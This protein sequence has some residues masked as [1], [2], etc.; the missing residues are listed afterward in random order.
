MQ[1][2]TMESF[3]ANICQMPDGTPGKCALG[4]RA[5]CPSALEAIL[6][7]PRVSR[8]SPS[9]EQIFTGTATFQPFS[10]LWICSSVSFQDMVGTLQQGYSPV[11]CGC[12]L[13]TAS[14]FLVFL[15]GCPS[16][17][18]PLPLRIWQKAGLVFSYE[19]PSVTLIS[20]SLGQ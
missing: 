15:P 7:Q 10:R 16:E 1:R 17:A 11:S 18:H 14:A 19:V 6:G 13:P 20:C 12:G 5:V 8:W 9:Q 3:S 4:R 2:T